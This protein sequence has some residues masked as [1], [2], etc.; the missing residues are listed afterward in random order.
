MWRCHIK[1][2]SINIDN[3][4][5]Q[6]VIIKFWRLTGPSKLRSF[7]RAIPSLIMWTLWKR[8]N[9]RRHGETSISTTWCYKFK[10]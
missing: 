5:L 10:H 6:Q 2:A 1:G 9:A 8:R 3:M 7:R 4:H